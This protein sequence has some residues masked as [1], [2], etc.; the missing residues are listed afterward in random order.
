MGK[1]YL[2]LPA[3]ACVPAQDFPEEESSFQRFESFPAKKLPL[4]RPK[5]LQNAVKNTRS[6]PSA[7][8]KAIKYAENLK[9]TLENWT[10]I[11]F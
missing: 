11:A 1:V 6:A 2:Q 10:A 7:T 8:A 3:V 4:K 9:I 5:Y